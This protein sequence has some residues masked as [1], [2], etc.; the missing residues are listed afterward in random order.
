MTWVLQ[1]V[2]RLSASRKVSRAPHHGAAKGCRPSRSDGQ[3]RDGVADLEGGAGR[4]PPGGQVRSH[5]LLYGKCVLG[6]T[7]VVQQQGD[8]QDCGARVCLALTRN[9]GGRAVDRL[10]HAG[11]RTRRVDVGAGSQGYA[12]GDSGRDVGQDVTEEVVRDD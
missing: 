7:K 3:S 1:D 4:G 8:G 9:V 10:E 6:A 11:S 5:S 2:R 12:T